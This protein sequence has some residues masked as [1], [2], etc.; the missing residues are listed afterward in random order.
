MAIV[1]GTDLSQPARAGVRAAAALARVLREPLWL[2]HVLDGP[3]E[4][5][6]AGLMTSLLPAVERR[7][8]QEARRVRRGRLDVRTK[9]LLGRAPE[10]LVSFAEAEKASLV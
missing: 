9:V 4:A 1:C 2:V 6:G 8:E 5:L 10:S 3:T 7:L